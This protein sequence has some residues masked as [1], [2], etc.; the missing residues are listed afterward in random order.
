MKNL[1][2]ITAICS[3]LLITQVPASAE[4][5][6]TLFPQ[7]T[8]K[9]QVAVCSIT[10]AKP[11]PGDLKGSTFLSLAARIK[12]LRS[13][14]KKHASSSLSKT[15]LNLLR[16][17]KIEG[18]ACR[19]GPPAILGKNAGQAQCAAADI[20]KDSIIEFRD[21]KRYASLLHKKNKKK[22]KKYDLTGDK[23]FNRADLDVV[24]GCWGPLNSSSSSSQSSSAPGI[25]CSW[26]AASP[27]FNCG[28]HVCEPKEDCSSCEAD[29]GACG[30]SA[31][32]YQDNFNDGNFDVADPSLEKSLSWNLAEGGAVVTQ[33]GLNGPS[34]TLLQQNVTILASPE[35]TGT[36]V[37]LEARA[38]IIWSHP[39]RIVFL[40]KDPANYYFLGLSGKRGLYR[41]MDGV[42]TQISDPVYDSW[43][44]VPHARLSQGRFKVYYR[45]YGSTIKFELDIDGFENGID[46]EET[47]EDA[48]AQAAARFQSGR[49]GF[50]GLHDD[51]NNYAGVHFDD[52]AIYS[53]HK[54]DQSLRPITTFYV[55]GQRG[56][57]N[58]PGTQDL[59]WKTI[60]KSA[61]TLMA[62]DTVLI[63]PG[64]YREGDIVPRFSGKR[65]SP[66]TY[67]A[68]DPNNPP[69]MEGTIKGNTLT[70]QL[71]SGSIYSTLIS[72]SPF[73][74][75]QNNVA[76]FIAQE[77]KQPDPDD[78]MNTDYFMTV[79]G[80]ENNDTLPE[81]HWQLTD[82]TFLNQP[83]QDFWKG[84]RLLL[85]D[86]YVNGI[87]SERDIVQYD[88]PNHRL[89]LPYGRWFSIGN[90]DKY[91]LRNHLS[92]LTRPGEYVIEKGLLNVESWQENPDQTL[93][94][95]ISM[96]SGPG[97]VS[98]VRFILLNATSG[99]EITADSNLQTGQTQTFK[100]NL[101]GTIQNVT[102]VYAAVQT[103][104]KYR[105]Y[106]WPYDGGSVQD[107][108]LTNFTSTFNFMHSY[109]EYL[110]FDGLETRYYE[111]SAFDFSSA[112]SVRNGLVRNCNIHRNGGGIAAR[113][114]A[115]GLLIEYNK[116]HHNYAN[117]ASFGGGRDYHVEHNEI[118]NNLD[119]G[120]WSGNGQALQFYVK[121]V[122]LCSNYIHNQGSDRTHP[123]NIQLY[124][125]DN[126]V[127]DGNLLVQEG[128]QN[129]WFSDNGT[130]HFTNN[131]VINGPAG[132]NSAPECY[133]YN[134]LFFNSVVR[135]DAAQEEDWYKTRHA[136]VRNNA[137][138]DSALTR[139]PEAL[140]P[141]M[142]ID[143]NFYSVTGYTLETWIDIGLGEGSIRNQDA[144]NPE[145]LKNYFVDPPRDFRLTAN[146]PLIDAGDMQP[147]TGRDFDGKR[148]F[149]GVRP[150]IG[151]YESANPLSF[152]DCFNGSMDPGET[153]IDCGGICQ[154]D[155]DGDGYP[156]K[157][158][159]SAAAILDCNDSDPAIHPQQ[160]E[161]ADGIDHNCDGQLH[162]ECSLD[163]DADGVNN[164]LDNCPAN[165]NPAQADQDQ[166]KIGDA[167]D[168]VF[169]YSD[170]FENRMTGPDDLATNK[171][172]NGLSW[173][174]ASGSA[175]VELYEGSKVVRIPNFEVGAQLLAAQEG[176]NTWQN[177]ALDI[178]VKKSWTS[179]HRG[180]AFHYR[181]AQN[182]YYLDLNQG[183]VVRRANGAD[184][185]LGR[186]EAL[187][188]AHGQN[189][190]HHYRIQ[191]RSSAG[192][193]SF[194]ISRD[195]A[196]PP[197]SFSDNPAPWAT[198]TIGL[199]FD[200][201]G[202][203]WDHLAA[204][205]VKV[206]VQ[207]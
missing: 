198:G 135:F 29:C 112:G 58:N 9:K 161:V 164:C 28:N 192:A 72:N 163:N 24:I 126:S 86:N 199:I 49:F 151:P 83:Q 63:A 66:I 194:E 130:I 43:L 189:E 202:S 110:V 65:G 8:S 10:S 92:L 85:Y 167:C 140:W 6:S 93:D 57:D 88:A 206:D 147:P 23:K 12:R 174:A 50:Q 131:I 45:N 160:P 22:T 3:I 190:M 59:P 146:S 15:L 148:R 207:L 71:H 197:S 137:F 149:Q 129:T 109:A 173:E 185:E 4:T 158:C 159:A 39:S 178:D 81:S 104:D 34:L 19:K 182:F 136:E 42:E 171:Q 68:A 168:S 51:P 89:T 184:V 186:S 31:L 46:F 162:P 73:A 67:K 108:T 5:P 105:L 1:L 118:Y 127:V 25:S 114:N 196:T 116:L 44:T 98:K 200:A 101:A 64:V 152:A 204:D 145:S 193:L 79:P 117:G 120:I 17:A 41:I 33:A 47:L 139:P 2:I 170:N 20:V 96:T 128:H 27:E 183:R 97:A 99:A 48:D 84:A 201:P 54:I 53:G 175:L 156:I 102:A 100:I 153:G 26:T 169:S 90:G 121:D 188:L 144:A 119:N 14:L 181:D 70:W 77:P 30:V 154:Q 143:H 37:T 87:D 142:I 55:D 13:K 115:E 187:A 75:Y 69:V 94:A 122:Y 52:V 91:A 40:Y 165:H 125:T 32:L 205:N 18:R 176:R 103:T 150:D 106:V 76:L 157:T 78:Q 133:V 36:E 21:L 179:P 195:N 74:I 203:A 177:Y 123:D 107:L 113:T 172:S 155:F 191:V 166:D 80:A 35:I 61:D 180:I 95:T 38:G 111:G 16:R 141:N 132:I 62:G 60:A 124:K 56:D 134:N 82:S 11:L 138:I 7:I